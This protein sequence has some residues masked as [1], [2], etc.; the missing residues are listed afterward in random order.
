MD[1]DDLV[2]EE[3]WRKYRIEHGTATY[4]DGQKYADLPVTKSPPEMTPD[5]RKRI[6]KEEARR[7]ARR[8]K[9]AEIERKRK[10]R[11]DEVEEKLKRIIHFRRQGLTLED[12]AMKMWV[13]KQHIS[14]FV[15]TQAP[16]EVREMFG[17]KG[18]RRDTQSETTSHQ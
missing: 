16:R 12:I 6:E 17:F 7:E 11:R 14:Q 4:K 10:A 13:T 5:Q 1:M 8:R 2:K 3:R 18:G 9:D 15:K